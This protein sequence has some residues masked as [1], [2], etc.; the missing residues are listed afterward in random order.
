MDKDIRLNYETKWTG[1]AGEMMM[2]DTNIIH[3][4]NRRQGAKIRDTIT[5]Y[6]TPGQALRKI[7]LD[8]DKID[9]I[10]SFKYKYLFKNSFFEARF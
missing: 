1:K 4:L 6:F 2:F 3:R 7:F 8:N 9:K 5:L 10:E